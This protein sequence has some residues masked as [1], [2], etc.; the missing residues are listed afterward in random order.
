MKSFFK[1]L[2]T[3]FFMALIVALLAYLIVIYIT[4]DEVWFAN[5]HDKHCEQ[6]TEETFNCNCYNR[7]LKE[8]KAERQQTEAANSINK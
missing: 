8:A 3:A 1:D 7:L 5:Q 2:I 6:L 4:S